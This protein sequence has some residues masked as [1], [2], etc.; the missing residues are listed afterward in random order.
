[1]SSERRITSSHFQVDAPEWKSGVSCGT[2]PIA[3]LSDSSWMSLM[4]CPSIVMRPLPAS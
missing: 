2:T 4:S 1:M 3:F